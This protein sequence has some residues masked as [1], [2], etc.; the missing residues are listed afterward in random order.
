MDLNQNGCQG[1]ITEVNKLTGVYNVT[2]RRN[3]V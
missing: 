2:V 3:N 1:N